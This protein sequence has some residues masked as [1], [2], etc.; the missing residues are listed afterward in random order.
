[1]TPISVKP[2][3]EPPLLALQAITKRFG[4][5]TAL[6]NVS[7]ELRSGSVHA[8]LGENGAGKT[9]LMRIAFGLLQPDAGHITVAGE[10]RRF[11]SPAAAIGAGIGMVHQQFSLIPAMTV[12]E[13]IA[14]GGRGNLAI[15]DVVSTIKSLG[16]RTGLRLDPF[17][18]VADLGPADRQKL[19]ILRTLAHDARILILDEPTAVLTERDISELFGQ[20][21]QYAATGNAVVLIT[22]KLRDA[23]T[24]A[25][26]ITILRRGKV[27][28]SA[29]AI[30][31]DEATLAAAMIGEG[32][33]ERVRSRREPTNPRARL[34][35]VMGV[36]IR[37]H[38]VLGV[39]ALEG[40]AK[41]FIR[42]LA[43]LPIKTGFVPENRQDDALIRS[44]SLTENLALTNAAGR[45]GIM[46]WST[47]EDAARKTIE[48][49]S[50]KA[51]G[52]DAKPD[53]L[54]G[55]NQQRFVLGREL[56]GNPDLLVL[57]NPTQGLDLK[58]TTFVHDQMRA[59]ADRGAAV[60]FY[61]SDL[62]ELAAV[63]DRVVVMSAKSWTEA[64]PSRDSIGN[65]LLSS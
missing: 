63:S 22:H 23:L 3:G 18:R 13:N 65:A 50:V 17:S 10:P 44:F 54:S 19:E 42:A 37:K 2:E 56:S 60:I 31:S 30:D 52:I 15:R 28:Y 40:A 26:Q 36:E 58:A 25:D 57:E 41:P 5:F 53:E 21:R 48:T 20:V 11:S 47:I 14:L 4:S 32:K 39:A 9:T 16:E 49:F 12:A 61:S 62:D 45:H 6:D 27:V 1:L 8:L 59:A 51:P 55:G 34:T 38:E 7:F 64:P 35:E 46:R 24:H 33:D 43:Q 29:A